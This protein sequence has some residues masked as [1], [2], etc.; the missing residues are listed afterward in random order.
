MDFPVT[1]SPQPAGVSPPGAAASAHGAGAPAEDQPDTAFADLLAAGLSGGAPD[2]ALQAAG[3]PTAAKAGGLLPAAD[4]STALPAAAD[5]PAALADD[6]A[7][8]LLLAALGAVP[9]SIT[10]PG[11]AAPALNQPQG[12][13]DRAQALAFAPAGDRR[14]RLA[15]PPVFEGPAGPRTS[16]AI[17]ADA[18]EAAG[19]RADAAPDLIE[20]PAAGPLDAH[21]AAVDARTAL[22]TAA[23][24]P[25][26]AE[27]RTPV[28]VSGWD[29]EL[30]KTLVW[31]A[32]GK[33]GVAELRLNPPD[34]G[35]L[36][37]VI[38]LGGDDGREARIAFASPHAAVRDAIE[39]AMPRLRDMMADSGI[40]LGQTSVN[41]ESSHRPD[42]PEPFRP[43]GAAGG[44]SGD[45]LAEP[46]PVPAVRTGIGIVDTF[47]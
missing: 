35:P 14:G 2:A 29:A 40:S 4:D 16:A 1:P 8:V 45:T 15:L 22:N 43:R 10:V 34:L 13:G 18:A 47:A 44:G 21:A 28:N 32:Q 6:P 11:A 9:I 33:H 31:M 46:H 30:G 20:Q 37:I 17:L 26:T 41:S 38:A 39:S 5:D 27:L 25:A 3:A 23:S 7:A 24:A 42:Y 19:K 36:R 12:A